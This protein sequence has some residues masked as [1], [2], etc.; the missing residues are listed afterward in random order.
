MVTL[1]G[2]RCEAGAASW[3]R[4][5]PSELDEPRARASG[6]R[7]HCHRRR[8]D[9]QTNRPWLVPSDAVSFGQRRRND[10]MNKICV[11]EGVGEGEN[12]RKIVPKRSFFLGNSMTIKFGNFTN[13]IFRNFVVIWEAPVLWAE[14]QYP[15]SGGT[16]LVS[17]LESSPQKTL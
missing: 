5:L 15:D 7:A 4:P 8:L 17:K 2:S 12:L 6:S 13:F 1:P 3:S 16:S 9:V 11:L 10:N 14:N